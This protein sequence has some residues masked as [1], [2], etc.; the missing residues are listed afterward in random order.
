MLLGRE[1]LCQLYL[2]V[3]FFPLKQ[4][5]S[6]IVV[7][8]GT[9]DK[10]FITKLLLSI[11]IILQMFLCKKQLKAAI[12]KLS[13]IILKLFPTLPLC[14]CFLT[15]MVKKQLGKGNVAQQIGKQPEPGC[16]LASLPSLFPL[17]HFSTNGLVMCS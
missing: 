6:K 12:I 4:K 13:F 17:R 14:F 1:Y 16:T 7:Y 3:N 15:F 2:K 10:S 9:A 8:I 11:A 5:S